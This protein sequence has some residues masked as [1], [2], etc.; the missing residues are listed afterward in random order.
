MAFNLVERHINTISTA[1]IRKLLKSY[2]AD[3]GRLYVKVGCDV[4]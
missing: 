3:S 2:Y 1:F 4:V